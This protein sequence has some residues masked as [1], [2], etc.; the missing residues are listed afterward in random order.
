MP[1]QMTGEPPHLAELREIQQKYRISFLEAQLK[2]AREEA[3]KEKL[4]ANEAEKDKK[5]YKRRAEEAEK[6]SDHARKVARQEH[7]AAR[8]EVIWPLPPMSRAPLGQLSSEFCIWR[9]SEHS[10]LRHTLLPPISI[11]SPTHW[12]QK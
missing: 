3:G 12:V 10:I 7:A 11:V 8:S 9:Q 2:E 4:R 5:S 1:T 6:D